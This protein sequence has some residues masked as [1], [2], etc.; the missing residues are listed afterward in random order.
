MALL[1]MIKRWVRME[2]SWIPDKPG[3]SLYIRP[4]FI[5]IQETLG[6]GPSNHALL[7]V[8]GCPVGQYYAG[9]SSVAIYAED[10]YVRAWPCGT[11]CYKIGGNYAPGILPQLEVSKDGYSQILWLLGDDH[12][13]TEVGTMNLFIFMRSKQGQLQLFTP[14][15]DGT[16]LPG[17]VRKSIL[18]MTREWNEFEVVEGSMNMSELQ[19]A[20]QEGRILEMFGSGTAV[21]ISPIHKIHWKGKDLMIPLDP[22]DPSKSS[23]PLAQRLWQSLIDIQYGKVAHAWSMAI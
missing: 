19:E 18:E 6:V 12:Q 11:G 22:T 2:E 10:K 7:Y 16:I 4:T 5:S 9:L 17:V 3:Y 14:K 1:E 13:L 23:G 21:V 8:I 15:L 20:L